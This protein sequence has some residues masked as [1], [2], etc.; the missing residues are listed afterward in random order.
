MEVGFGI[1]P[2]IRR[3][4]KQN[5]PVCGAKRVAQTDPSGENAPR[6]IVSDR[7][8]TA[9]EWERERFGRDRAESGHCA[10]IVDR[11]KMISLCKRRI[12]C[13]DPR[14][15]MLVQFAGGSDEA[16]RCGDLSRPDHAVS[17]TLGRLHRRGQSGSGIDVFVE[18]LDLSWA[19]VRWG[20]PEVIVALRVN[21][22]N[23]E[24]Q[25]SEHPAPYLRRN[26]PRR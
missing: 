6:Y 11:S 3:L 17:G 13:F 18:E 10:D 26:V 14:D 25:H 21:F 12:A 8:M 19:W 4:P 20:R 15:K 1:A 2:T 22:P 16:L 9:E 5:W 23:L 24:N 7:P